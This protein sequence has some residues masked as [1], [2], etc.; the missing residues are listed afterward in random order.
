MTG[1]L[2]APAKLV[3]HRRFWRQQH[4]SDGTSDRVNL[5]ARGRS[6]EHIAI[7]PTIVE[8]RR[9]DYTLLTSYMGNMESRRALGQSAGSPIAPGFS[10][11][12]VSSSST[13]PRITLLRFDEGPQQGAAP[14]RPGCVPVG[15]PTMRDRRPTAF[16]PPNRRTGRPL[17]RDDHRADRVP[18]WNRNTSAAADGRSKE[19]RC[20]L[21]F[22]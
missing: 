14:A 6:G 19:S 13:K 15:H 9:G 18:R 21:H 10:D 8:A 2:G 22:P 17:Q 7:E 20:N 1:S 4:L 12:V 11:K 3:S 16:S 5:L